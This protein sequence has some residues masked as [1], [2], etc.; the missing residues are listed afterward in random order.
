MK[1]LVID[2]GLP[3]AVK[4]Y[5]TY[6]VLPWIEKGSSGAIR[7]D[8]RRSVEVRE[9][10][11]YHYDIVIPEKYYMPHVY[12]LILFA[13]QAGCKVWIDDD[14]ARLDIPKGNKGRKFYLVQENRERVQKALQLADLITVTTPALKKM[15]RGYNQNIHVVP[16]A[17][18]DYR[19]SKSDPT[20]QSKPTKIIWRGHDTHDPDLADIQKPLIDIYRRRAEFDFKFL[21]HSPAYI[22]LQPSEEIPATNIGG[23]FSLLKAL[24]GDFLFVPL[25]NHDFN[26]AK[27][28]IALIEALLAG[29]PA[30]APM[31]MPEFDRPGVIR[32]NG[33]A[34]IPKVFSRITQ[35]QY[36][37]EELVS[38]GQEWL[39]EIRLSKVNTLR[40][41]AIETMWQ[42][43]FKI[44]DAKRKYQQHKD[45]ESL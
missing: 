44:S 8:F 32:Y 14:D 31:S 18:N 3:D 42:V 7:F 26:K 1:I 6:G 10:D 21:G 30:I 43:D 24:R 17:W 36:D 15:Y 2:D 41:A 39:E 4:F 5:R 11:F 23:Y 34:D 12:Q 45:E 19:F 28:N 9:I 16:N 20:P 22:D 38:Q 37:K 25:L 27:S 33:N 29:M 13:K 35:K 40:V